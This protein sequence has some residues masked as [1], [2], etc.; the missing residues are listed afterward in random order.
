[1]NDEIL[2]ITEEDLQAASNLDLMGTNV[3]NLSDSS[4]AGWNP[5]LQPRPSKEAVDVILCIDTSGSMAA[6]DYNPNRL[7][8]AKEAACMFTR[9]KVMQN[10]NDRVGILGFGGSA[11]LIHPLDSDLDKVAAAISSLSITHTGTMAGLALQAAQKELLR[12]NGKKRAIVLL[13]DGGDQYDSS[14]PVQAASSQKGIKIFTIGIGTV[15]GADVAIPAVGTRRVVLN[16]DLLRQVAKAG[17]GEYLYA[18]DV[19]VL[20][21]I[22]LKL[23]DY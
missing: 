22:Y 18:P 7:E 19:A 10:Y 20:Q 6:N 15:K 17:G 8:A 21:R 1:M 2:R 9:R 14:N 11:T 12:H 23:A 16:E 3:P 13:S 4:L 5:E